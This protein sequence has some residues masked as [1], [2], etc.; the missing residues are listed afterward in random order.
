[1]SADTVS[2]YCYTMRRL[3]RAIIETELFCS[4]QAGCASLAAA[5]FVTSLKLA[6]SPAAGSSGVAGSCAV[7]GAFFS[8]CRIGAATNG[9]VIPTPATYFTDVA[10]GNV[11]TLDAAGTA[12]VVAVGAAVL[13]AGA[14]SAV[15]KQCAL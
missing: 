9:G 14:R 15:C 10:L 8:V 13:A 5:R 7:D 11:W 2:A 6:K 4:V 12:T 3:S 1:M